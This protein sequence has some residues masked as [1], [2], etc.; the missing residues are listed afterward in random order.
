MNSEI[1]VKEPN[2]YKAL[3]IL[4]SIFV[5]P[6]S[7]LDNQKVVTGAERLDILIP[8]IANK[9]IG[10]AV[11]QTSMINATHLVDTLLTLNMNIV[12]IFAPEHGFKGKVERGLTVENDEYLNTGIP[13]FSIYG[14]ARKPA[15]E[16]LT[17]IDVMLFDI[18]DVGVRFFT[19]ISTMHY[20]M[21]A[22]AENKIPVIVLDRPNPIGHYVDGPIMEQAFT[23]FV[24][25]H[26]VPVAHGMTI[27]EYALMINGEG[28][29]KEGIKC[30]L[31]VIT[32]KNYTHSLRYHLPVS[33][34]PNLPD[35]KSVY[36]Y[37][38][39]CFFEGTDVSEGRG[40]D[41]PFQQFGAPYFKPR[42]HQFTPV[43]KPG[44]AVN[45][46]YEGE[47]CYGYDLSTRSIHELEQIDKIQ[48]RYLIEFYKKSPD[49]ESYFIPFF[50]RLA[51]TASLR[52]QIIDG[53]T[54]QEIR[55][56][57]EPGL[58]KYRQL[59]KKYLQYPE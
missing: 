23:S 33:P 46:K 1:H 37:P 41:I 56:S 42:V 57:W 14:A 26:Q 38:S 36:L 24:G 2:M 51:G 59:R 47:I 13:I 19:Y 35:M 52:Q 8:M 21:E 27:G 18:Q 55:A 40:T 28:W 12:G 44:I 16:M 54:E 34:S 9:K 7:A 3:I 31:T 45:P 17:G 11:N 49:K 4:I 6:A 53:M 43:S 58:K 32:M 25:M 5:I 30:D 29:L 20:V 15:A 48:L 50:E 39:I 10:L 22:C